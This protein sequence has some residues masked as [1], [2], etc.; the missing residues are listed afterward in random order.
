MSPKLALLFVFVDLVRASDCTSGESCADSEVLLQA[1]T[2]VQKFSGRIETQAALGKVETHT[3][4]EALLAL[5]HTV[6]AVHTS[7]EGSRQLRVTFSH[8]G[9]QYNYKLAPH[10]V[11][12]KDA[13]IFQDGVLLKQGADSYSRTFR[14]RGHGNGASV[15]V[16]GNKMVQGLFEHEG[17]L[18]E[19]SPV[20]HYDDHAATLLQSSKY[21]S[22]EHPAH[23]IRWVAAPDLGTLGKKLGLTLSETKHAKVGNDTHGFGGDLP[24]QIADFGDDSHIPKDTADHY[25]DFP[26]V[27]WKG[28]KWWP[29]CYQGDFEMQ[30]F[31]LTMVA[32]K[33]ANDHAIE[34]D[35]NMTAI[36]ESH[37]NEASWIYEQQMHVRLK[38]GHL[39]IDANGSTFG[40]CP[41]KK[42]EEVYDRLYKIKEK[43]ESG[44]VPAGGATHILTGCGERFSGFAGLAYRGKICEGEW[45]VGA[46]KTY[47]FSA[48]LVFA[49]E[50]GHN[51]GAGH[52]FEKGQGT[53]GGIM[54]YGDGL[55]DGEYQFNSNR[56]DEICN[57]IDS[58]LGECDGKFQK[59]PSPPATPQTPHDPFEGMDPFSEGGGWDYGAIVEETPPPIV[60]PTLKPGAPLPY[61]KGDRF[62]FD[63]GSGH[64][65]QCKW[66]AVDRTWCHHDRQT[67]TPRGGVPE[68]NGLYAYEVCSECGMCRDKVSTE[69]YVCT[70]HY[71]Q[72]CTCHGEMYLGK[73]YIAGNSGSYLPFE[74]MKKGEHVHTPI[75]PGMAFD[76]KL[77]GEDATERI[78]ATGAV[79]RGP[80]KGTALKC[81]SGDCPY[82]AGT[83]SPKVLR[84]LLYKNQMCWC[85]PSVP[86]TVF[87]PISVC[88]KT[89]GRMSS[90]Y[91]CKCGTT[92]QA[93]TQ[94]ADGTACFASS[95]TDGKCHK[96]CETHLCPIGQKVKP[97]AEAT[98]KI[99]A[100]ES[101]NKEDDALCCEGPASGLCCEGPACL[102][103]VPCP[104]PPSDNT[105]FGSGTG[106]PGYGS[107]S[108]FGTGAG[109]PDGT[110]AGAADGTG[111]GA[112]AGTGS[113]S[114][115]PGKGGKGKGGKGAPPSDKGFGTAADYGSDSG[116]P[117]YG[118]GGSGPGAPPSDNPAAPPSWR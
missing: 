70:W 111:A 16:L 91:P 85:D 92:V 23:L 28:V 3:K 101:D 115:A 58:V 68:N 40:E 86:S 76:G 66:F 82:T 59:D 41:T 38:I 42:K 116:A 109:A 98:V 78:L 93:A 54:D 113:D 64:N 87:G 26:A 45:A 114:G 2:E 39:D 56:K 10:S 117:D 106:A 50:L 88:S 62:S 75:N 24:N 61:C 105:G 29:G 37:V 79:W 46:Y 69:P 118:S 95:D 107:D 67:V 19:I 5:G 43:I 47:V 7:M 80:F 33:A 63:A 22:D 90:T 96:T 17:R 83:W 100:E 57:K 60:K 21:E 12:T 102:R 4:L 6:G 99:H 30:E 34:L 65:V 104:A 49:H 72:F 103:L 32:D 31:I 110:G 13:A 25:P 97:G 89:D 108:G 14:A 53:T 77:F 8:E 18:L 51:F 35:A 74:E 15:T 20:S 81:K 27:G 52:S 9:R 112:G 36:V 73:K 44:K 48:W 55:L 11:Y 94:C 71:G 1:R 84:D